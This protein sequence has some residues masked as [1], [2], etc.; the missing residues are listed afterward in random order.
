MFKEKN[1]ADTTCLGTI[2]YAAP[3]QFGGMGQTDARTDIY[4]LG[5]TMY[6]LVTG[7]NPGEPPYEIRLIRQINQELS[8][9]LEKI[10]QSLARR[11][12]S[13]RAD[14]RAR[15]F[16]CAI[17]TSARYSGALPPRAVASAR[18]RKARSAV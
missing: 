1:P 10:I 6:H 13:S 2:G 3:E 5:A 15:A 12:R 14:A 9:G 7:C 17:R 11:R 8:G 16:Q 18:I 4:C